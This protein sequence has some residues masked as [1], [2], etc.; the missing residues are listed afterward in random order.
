MSP[1]VIDAIAGLF[2]TAVVGV[3]VYV[4]RDLTDYKNVACFSTEAGAWVGFHAGVTI[5]RDGEYLVVRKG[6]PPR[7]VARYHQSLLC[8]DALTGTRS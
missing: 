8:L 1:K 7:D 4:V 3:G 5:R 2:A 6:F